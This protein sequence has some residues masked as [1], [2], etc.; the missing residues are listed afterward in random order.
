ML[1]D[2]LP[3][4]VRRW[5]YAV[6][7]VASAAGVFDLLPSGWSERVAAVLMAAGFTMAAGNTGSTPTDAQGGEGAGE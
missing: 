6:L 4:R 2:L 7:A 3:S 5:V 1:R